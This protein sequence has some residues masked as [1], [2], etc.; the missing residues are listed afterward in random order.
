MIDSKETGEDRRNRQKEEEIESEMR[1][2]GERKEC[3]S[4]KV[5]ERGER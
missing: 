4:K 3:E 1:M 5:K 2:R